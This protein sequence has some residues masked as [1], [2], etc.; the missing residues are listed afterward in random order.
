MPS[1]VSPHSSV[2]R[3]MMMGRSGQ[4]R[5]RVAKET[6][7]D[8]VFP[9][10]AAKRAAR[11]MGE[12]RRGRARAVLRS[13]RLLSQSRTRNRLK[14][15]PW[16]QRLPLT[17][18]LQH[19]RQL[20]RRWRLSDHRVK[21]VRC[22]QLLEI[23]RHGHDGRMR[24]GILGVPNHACHIGPVDPRQFELHHDDVKF[25]IAHGEPRRLI[26]IAHGD[27]TAAELLQQRFH[28]QT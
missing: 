6:R 27:G 9:T 25:D 19:V 23:A 18:F 15:R 7:A 11:H 4:D 2:W 12:A 26:P 16:G 5:F 10:R 24:I 22:L 14:Q 13:H 8:R 3:L 28:D 1:P 21:V 17:Q 20:L